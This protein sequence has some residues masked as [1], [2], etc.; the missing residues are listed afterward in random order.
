MLTPKQEQGFDLAEKILMRIMNEKDC[1][2]Q[3]AFITYKG[4]Q[5]MQK[6]GV[7]RFVIQSYYLALD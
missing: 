4:L 6:I 2:W 5:Q 7:S 1:T 3:E